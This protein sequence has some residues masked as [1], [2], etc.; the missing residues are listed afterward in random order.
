[1][2]LT[3]HRQQEMT[4]GGFDAQISTHRSSAHDSI[5]RGIDVQVLLFNRSALCIALI[6]CVYWRQANIIIEYVYAA[7]ERSNSISRFE[8]HS[9]V[10][11]YV[12]HRTG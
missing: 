6:G 1:M 4:E 12:D 11:Y 7:R 9:Y 3:D 2:P 10:A 8:S 5:D